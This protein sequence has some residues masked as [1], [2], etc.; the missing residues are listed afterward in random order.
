M[1]SPSFRK[2]W[3][4]RLE[5]Y[6]STRLPARSFLGLQEFIS[7]ESGGEEPKEAY[8]RALLDGK[9]WME[10]TIN[11]IASLY[12]TQEW[13]GWLQLEEDFATDPTLLRMIRQRVNA[14]IRGHAFSSDRRSS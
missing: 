9:R 12:G 7:F 2:A 8:G 4:S 14:A 1:S 5:R 10:W 13:P 3:I 6:C 11:E